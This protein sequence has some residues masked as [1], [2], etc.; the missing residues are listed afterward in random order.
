MGTLTTIVLPWLL[1]ASAS[2]FTSSPQIARRG[3]LTP[4]MAGIRVPPLTP[5][6]VTLYGFG[7]RAPHESAT[8]SPGSLPNSRCPSRRQTIA[9]WPVFKP[10]CRPS[11][12]RP[13]HRRWPHCRRRIT[14]HCFVLP[15]SS[16]PST[17]PL[18]RL[19]WLLS[20]APPNPPRPPQVHL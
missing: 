11:S 10:S 13:R 8:P 6:V 16:K 5:T 18:S 14:T 15:P 7:L 3:P 1:P 9:S 19:H 20:Q 17:T 12:S 2:S 4:K